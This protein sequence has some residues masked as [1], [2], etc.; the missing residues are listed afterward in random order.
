AWVH[1]R[2]RVPV[3]AI[4]LQSA[5]TM[6]ILLTGSYEKI[7]DYVTSMDWIFFGLTASCLFVLRRRGGPAQ[8]FRMPGHPW[9]TGFFCLICAAVV[10]NTVYRFPNNTVIGLAILATGVPVYYIW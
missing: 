8:T 7:L 6:V 2:T 5:W 1:P 3:I 4:A 9:T 10:S